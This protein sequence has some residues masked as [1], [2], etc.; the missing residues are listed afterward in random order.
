MVE[1]LDRM[2][3][4]TAAALDPKASSDLHHA[5]RVRGAHKVRPGISYSRHLVTSDVCTEIG[6]RHPVDSSTSTALVR[7]SNHP[8]LHTRHGIENLQRLRRHTLRVHQVARMVVCDTA[9]HGRASTR[10]NCR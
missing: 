9:C 3:D 10:P 8:N 6:V 4:I 7:L 5:P 1:K 2:N